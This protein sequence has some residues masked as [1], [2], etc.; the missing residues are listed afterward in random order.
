MPRSS[1]VGSQA[2]LRILGGEK[3]EVTALNQNIN[4]YFSLSLGG[5]SRKKDPFLRRMK[6]LERSKQLRKRQELLE[7]EFLKY[8]YKKSKAQKKRRK[9]GSKRSR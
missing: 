8:A 5:G 6:R 1:Y 7:K 3:E 2:D 9:V 4:N